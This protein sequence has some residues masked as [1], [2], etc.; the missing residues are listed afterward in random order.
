LST[1]VFLD[2]YSNYFNRIINTNDSLEEYLSGR[3]SKTFQNIQFKPNDS[4]FTSIIINWDQEWNPDYLLVM[5]ENNNLKSRWFVVESTRTREGQYN[6]QL[7]RDTVADYK[8]LITNAP[9]FVEKGKLSSNDPLIYNSEGMSFNQIKSQE[10]LLKD[11]TQMPWVVGYC[12]QD[13]ERHPN[14]GYYE[15]SSKIKTLIS[16]TSIPTW[17]RNAI[18][19][20]KKFALYEDSEAPLSAL[21]KVQTYR[22]ATATSNINWTSLNIENVYDDSSNIRIGRDEDTVKNWNSLIEMNYQ[23][24]NVVLGISWEDHDDA[25]QRNTKKI[26]S[27]IF[28]SFNHANNVERISLME[29]FRNDTGVDSYSRYQ[30]LM[31]YKDLIYKED[32]HYYKLKV[33]LGVDISSIIIPTIIPTIPRNRNSYTK[34]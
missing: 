16:S 29:G 23:N 13:T 4:V 17:I 33:Q 21:F 11:E 5:D 27:E 32:D 2:K 7:K 14:S 20:N 10:I 26:L 1:L 34:I 24:G 19:T 31:K 6:V 30:T 3:N 15:G 12:V 25:L 22:K 28:E 9:T 8:G 18:G